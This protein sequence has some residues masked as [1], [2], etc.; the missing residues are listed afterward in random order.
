MLV[1]PDI[2]KHSLELQTLFLLL[3]VSIAALKLSLVP[4]PSRTPANIIRDYYSIH[5]KTRRSGRFGDVMMMSGGCVLSLG[6]RGWGLPGYEALRHYTA[7]AH[8]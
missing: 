1:R 5:L 8:A 6:V 3:N 2:Q 7:N 4:R